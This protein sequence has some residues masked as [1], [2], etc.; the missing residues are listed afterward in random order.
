[1]VLS[2]SLERNTALVSSMCFGQGAPFSIALSISTRSCK[3][4]TTLI[5]GL[6]VLIGILEV[7]ISVL[8]DL[9]GFL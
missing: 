9:I 8:E 3:D 7:L 6:E 5:G 1:M 2:G 4:K